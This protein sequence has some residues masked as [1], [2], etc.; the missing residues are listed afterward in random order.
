MIAYLKGNLISINQNKIV[1]LVNNV[2]YEVLIPSFLLQTINSSKLDEEISVY[3]YY[4][5]TEKQPK[6]ILIGFNLETERTFFE[7]FISVDAIGP[8][9]A[10][11]ALNV[12]I[13][14]VA[15]AIETS[16]TKKLEKLKGIGK[17]SAEK[18]VATL[19]GTLKEFV[20]EM[21]QEYLPESETI[22]EDIKQQVI[23]VLVNKL[24]YKQIEAFNL[25]KEATKKNPLIAT[26]EEL[27]DEIYKS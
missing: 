19:K 18:I 5:Q 10:V 24:G 21:E 7:K 6:P 11:N 22:D 4:H 13:N 1:I 27:F 2:G 23:D 8:I 14:E 9:K 17:R 15:Q 3:I 20:V 16:N 12:S 25:I 26:A